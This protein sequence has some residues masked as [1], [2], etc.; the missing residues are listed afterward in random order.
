MSRPIRIR[1]A[2]SCIVLVTCIFLAFETRAESDHHAVVRDWRG[3]PVLTQLSGTC[4]RTKWMESHDVCHPDI[5]E[6]VV[7]HTQRRQLSQEERTVYFPFNIASLTPDARGRLDTLATN[8]KSQDDVKGARVVGFADRIGTASYNEA[9]S[10]MR[11][12]NV[13]SYLVSK[14]IV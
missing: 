13:K 7:Q 3:Y 10:K 12:E 1:L 14:G 2:L 4:V 9:L 8:I 5:A 11:A 6:T